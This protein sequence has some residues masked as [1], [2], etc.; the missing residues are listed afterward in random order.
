MSSWT[1]RQ[2]YARTRARQP[3]ASSF[4]TAPSRSAPPIAR[5]QAAPLTRSTYA[6]VYRAFCA[7][8]GWPDAGPDAVTA[9]S[10]RAYRDRLEQ[11]GRSPSTAS[12]RYAAQRSPTANR[13]R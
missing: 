5:Q 12:G 11:E 4:T 13:A 7:F 1:P 10:V 9:A 3:A 2:H 8:S 6:G